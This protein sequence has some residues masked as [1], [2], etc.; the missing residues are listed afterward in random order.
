MSNEEGFA[1]VEWLGPIPGQYQG[2]G[3]AKVR[4]FVIHVMQGAELDGCDSWFHNPEARV[5]AHFGVGRDGAA[6]QWVLTTSAAWACGYFNGVSVSIEHAGFS[7]QRLTA[8]QLA[9][10]M[11]ILEHL[12]EL[13]PSVPLEWTSDPA[14]TGVTA[15]GILGVAGGNHPDCPGAPIKKQVNKALHQL[16]RRPRVA[17]KRSVLRRPNG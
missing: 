16:Q 5:G 3:G 11:R 15:H 7:G 14:G 17:V 6:D 1:G 2:R 4:L 8:P 12:H 13:Y 10:T 9:T